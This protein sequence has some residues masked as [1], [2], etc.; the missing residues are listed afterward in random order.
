MSTFE[1]WLILCC[2]LVV[3]A[4]CRL[5]IGD[6]YLVYFNSWLLLSNNL[7]WFRFHSVA[8]H[9]LTV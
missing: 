1:P 4:S 7:P 8:L 3:L 6:V 2:L 9:S 5:G